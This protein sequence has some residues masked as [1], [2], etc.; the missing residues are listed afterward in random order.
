[1]TANNSQ[2]ATLD[3]SRTNEERDRLRGPA[4]QTIDHLVEAQ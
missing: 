2:P 3:E 1:M 4:S